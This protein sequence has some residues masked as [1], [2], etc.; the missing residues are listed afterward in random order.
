MPD[1]LD[2]DELRP[3]G[4]HALKARVVVGQQLDLG[5]DVLELR[6]DLVEPDRRARHPA[7]QSEQVEHLRRSLADRHGRRWR[8]LK[9]D[10]LATVFECQRIFR[11]LRRSR[12][13]KESEATG[14]ECQAQNG[15]NAKISD[16]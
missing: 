11:G 5:I 3:L 12:G 14:S 6:Q 8:L 16:R 7:A 4:D 15:H 10:G 9:R 2:R 1:E 13:G